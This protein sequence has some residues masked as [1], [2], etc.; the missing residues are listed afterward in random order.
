MTLKTFII[1][2]LITFGISF[3]IGYWFFK[4]KNGGEGANAPHKDSAVR[5]ATIWA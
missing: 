5:I 2:S 1:S 4:Q 3:A